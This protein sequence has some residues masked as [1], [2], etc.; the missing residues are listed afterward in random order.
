MGSQD[1]QKVAPPGQ[2]VDIGGFRLHTLVC[3]QGA[4]TVI[5]EPAL[6]GF[7]LQY[8]HIQSAVSALTRVLAYDRAGQGWSDRS[9]NPRTPANLAGELK[10]V[11]GKL[12]LQPPYVLV[13]HSFGGLVARFYAGFHPEEVVGVILVDSSD[14][15]QYDTF[16]NLDKM[17]SQTATGV[18]LLKFVSRLGLGK[19]LTKMSMGN[20]TKDL[21]REDLNNFLAI[22]SQPR[23]QETVLAEF[24]QHRFYFGAQ[25]EV[26]RTLGNT[27][28]IIFT[29]GNSVSG[30]GKFGG[31]TIAEL[32]AKHQQ[33]QKNLIQ[34]SSQSEQVILPAATHLSI[35]IQPEYVAQVADAVRRLVE[36]VREEKQSPAPTSP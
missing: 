19:S 10:A 35:L 4:P 23:H 1:Q 6:G 17:V 27:P 18:R 26:P 9:P 31:M 2:M 8:T 34:L 28:L 21:P 29:A 36:R 13:G 33:W 30:Q 16:P 7:A 5:L 32:N 24:T 12:D 14:V 25:S 15:E 20:A 3:G 11:L 22:A